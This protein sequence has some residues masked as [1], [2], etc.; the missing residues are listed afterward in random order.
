MAKLTLD[1]HPIHNRGSAIEAELHRVMDE[2]EAKRIKTVEII[3]GK[4]SGQLKK[5]VLK[6]LERPDIKARY[7]RVDKDAKNHGR[8]FVYFRF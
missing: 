3:P 6:F 7:H 8:L 4:G 1:L 5:R 2:A